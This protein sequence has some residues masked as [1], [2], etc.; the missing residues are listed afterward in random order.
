MNACGP[1]MTAYGSLDL[2]NKKS[3]SYGDAFLEVPCPIVLWCVPDDNPSFTHHPPKAF[4]LMR[5]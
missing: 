4:M 1:A 3:E 5:I 2:S